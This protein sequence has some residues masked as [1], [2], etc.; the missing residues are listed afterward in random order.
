MDD[1]LYVT[2]GEESENEE[3][4][5]TSFINVPLGKQLKFV[6]IYII[7]NCW[8][9]KSRGYSF[10]LFV[11]LQVYSEQSTNVKSNDGL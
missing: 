2:A 8:I 3:N 11:E 6:S 4:W 1:S 5:M 7:A 9:K 10:N